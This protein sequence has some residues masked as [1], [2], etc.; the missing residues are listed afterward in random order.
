M[1]QVDRLNPSA[2]LDLYIRTPGG[3]VIPARTVASIKYDVV[4]ESI[5]RFQQLNSATISGVSGVSQGE[6]LEF[7]RNTVKELAPRDI[8]SITPASRASSCRSRAASW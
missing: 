7:M 2:A 5:T 4:P 8:R 6:V 3:G 1:Q